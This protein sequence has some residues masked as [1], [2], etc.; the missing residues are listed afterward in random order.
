VSKSEKPH[1]E[2]PSY[3]LD[4]TEESAGW[5]RWLRGW[6]RAL[7]LSL[8]AL[9]LIV[10]FGAKPAYREVKAR[11]A[12]SLAEGAGTALDRG[13]GAE[14]SE[15][16][17]QAALMA[18]D[19]E[20]VADLVTYQAARAGD[21]ASVAEIGKKLDAGEAS[22][23]EIL[24]FGER[25]LSAGRADDARRALEALP[26][27]RLAPDE[28]VRRAVLEAGLLAGLGQAERA[29]SVLRQALPLAPD[30]GADRL[31]VALANLLLSGAE[32]GR[33]G[34]ARELL[35]A[36]AE[37]DDEA[38]LDARRVLA[39]S[40]AGLSPGAQAELSAAVARLRAHPRAS[41]ADELLV[42]RLMVSSDP[43]RSGEAAK[44]L[45][46][47]LRE[48]SAPLDDRVAAA[49]WLVGLPA[50]EAVLEL[51]QAD[52]VSGHAGALMV[53]LDALSGLGRWDECRALIETHR[54]GALPDTLYHLFAAR[55]AGATGDPEGADEAK[56]ELRRAVQF[57]ELPHVLFAARYAE[58]VGWKPEAFASWRILA[59]DSGAKTEALR[60]QIRNLP[61]TATAA[62]GLAVTRELLAVLPGDASGRLSAAY[63][64]LLAGGASD[65]AVAT[66]DEFLAADPG[67]VDIRRVAALARLR[68][69]RPEEGLAL[70]P[71]DGGE[72]RWSAL[73]TALLRAAGQD[74]EADQ[75]AAGV[76]ATGLLPEERALLQ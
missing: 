38:A 72:S 53:R 71:E 8:A 64:S 27:E 16:L 29:E 15:L 67:S 58:A 12:L 46:S 1:P 54:G 34:E 32:S 4:E 13:E 31:R 61:P 28:L 70:L 63:F 18:F 56:R 73:R 24:V 74:A 14:A 30:P 6:R 52:E 7:I 42:A 25:S 22:A 39:A 35:E 55:I 3:V 75:L 5:R 19:D 66:A 36:A 69:G 37:G 41:T 57:D 49:R 33:T 59:A 60:G 23:G 76:D 26:A 44:D 21:P 20:R 62:D 43:A 47:R 48:R 11:R 50:H 10:G 40:T 51:V 65:E 68:G 2:L 45:V 17:R 9:V